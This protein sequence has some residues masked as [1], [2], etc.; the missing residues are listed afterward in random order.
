MKQR[1]TTYVST[2]LFISIK[3]IDRHSQHEE[4]H[5]K[6]TYHLLDIKF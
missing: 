1:H 6:H 2:M 4:R 5:D 3:T